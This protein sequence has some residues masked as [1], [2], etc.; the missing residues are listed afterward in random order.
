L[1]GVQARV[2]RFLILRGTLDHGSKTFKFFDGTF[3][4]T[5]RML[6]W[7]SRTFKYDFSKQN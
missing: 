1:D 7:N 3:H 4:L 2:V 6:F 5:W